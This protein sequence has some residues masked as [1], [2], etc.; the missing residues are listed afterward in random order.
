MG[1]VGIGKVA[2]GHGAAVRTVFFV[3]RWELPEV[4]TTPN[5]RSKMAFPFEFSGTFAR[6][7]TRLNA[8]EGFINLITILASTFNHALNYTP[9]R[10][11]K[12]AWI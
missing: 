2:G 11:V 7:K 10:T 12:Q 6:A 4:F 3:R 1:W 5:A 8:G 9:Y